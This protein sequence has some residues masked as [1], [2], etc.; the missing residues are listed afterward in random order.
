MRDL[1]NLDRGIM[2]QWLNSRAEISHRP[3]PRGERAMLRFRQTKT[4][5]NFVSVHVSYFNDF[6]SERHLIDRQASKIR[7]SPPLAEWQNLAA[8]GDCGLY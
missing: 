1:G 4:L 7:R 6:T 3:F 2:E 8:C 5:Q